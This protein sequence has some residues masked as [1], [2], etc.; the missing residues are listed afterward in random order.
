[1]TVLFVNSSLTQKWPSFWALVFCLMSSEVIYAQLMYYWKLLSL[2]VSFM[3]L[4]LACLG[5]LH[6]LVASGFVC[7]LED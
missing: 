2:L 5:L 1:M 6:V 3:L 4:C 7:P